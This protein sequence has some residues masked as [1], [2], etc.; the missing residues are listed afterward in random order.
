MRGQVLVEENRRYHKLKRICWGLFCGTLALIV[1]VLILLYL[2]SQGPARGER[3]V[4]RLTDH[5]FRFAGQEVP[6]ELYVDPRSLTEASAVPED[7][8]P[9]DILIGLDNSLSMTFEDSDET[10][11]ERVKKV[12]LSFLDST[13][14]ERHQVGIARLDEEARVLQTLSR[15][16]PVLKRVVEELPE[17]QSTKV[18]DGLEAMGRELAS[19]RHQPGALSLAIVLTDGRTNAAALRSAAS[20]LTD[21]QRV[22]VAPIGIGDFV[23]DD[24]LRAVSSFPSE[25]SKGTEVDEL[26]AIYR[27]WIENMER[28]VAIDVRLTETFNS[29]SLSLVEASVSDGGVVAD[30]R[31]EWYLPFLTTRPRSLSYRLKARSIGW[32]SIDEVQGSVAL[33]PVGAQEVILPVHRKPKVI[34]TIPL[35][36]LLIPLLLFLLLLPWLLAWWRRRRAAAGPARLPVEIDQPALPPMPPPLLPLDPEQLMRTTEPTLILGLGGAGR[37]VLTF[38]KKAVL[39]TNYGRL[40]KT[41]RFLVFDTHS[42]ELAESRV[43]VGGVELE[44]DELVLLHEDPENPTELLDRTRRMADNPGVDPHLRD[45]WPVEDFKNLPAEQLQ[46]SRGTNQRRPMGRM[47]LYLDLEDGPESSRLWSSIG[48]AIRELKEH[49]DPTVFLAASASGGT[50]SGMFIDVAYL[51]RKI[52]YAEGAKGVTVNLLLALQNTYASLSDSLGLT[53]PNAFAALKE[54]D[55]LLACRDRRLPMTYSPEATNPANGRLDSP[56]LDNCYLFDAQRESYPLVGEHP[57]RGIYPAMAD[58]IHTFLYTTPGGAFDQELK[59]RKVVGDLEQEESGHG[60][61]SSLGTFVFRLPMYDFLQSLKYRFARELAA[62]YFGVFRDENGHWSQTILLATDQEATAENLEEFLYEPGDDRS[63]AEILQSIAS[64]DPEWLYAIVEADNAYKAREDY[65]G[66]HRSNAQRHLSAFAMGLLNPDLDRGT[67]IEEPGRRYAMT[68]STFR[69]LHHRVALYRRQCQ[70]RS[71][72]GFDRS[73]SAIVDHI[74]VVYEE[75]AE[76]IIESLQAHLEGVMGSPEAENATSL[77]THIEE[78]EGRQIANRELESGVLVREYFY[79]DD[80]EEK[81]YR[82]YLSE[83]TRSDSLQRFVWHCRGTANGIALELKLVAEEEKLLRPYGEA[84]TE[85][86][87]TLTG[88][89]ELLLQPMWDQDIHPYIQEAH[90]DPGALADKLFERANP[91]IEIDRALAVRHTSKLFTTLREDSYG[92][93]VVTQIYPKFSRR[94]H[95]KRTEFRDPHCFSAVIVL[96]SLPL[97]SLRAYSQGEISYLGV[98]A[99]HLPGLHILGVEHIASRMEQRLERVKEA[100]RAFHPRFI[101][102]LAELERVRQF[103]ECL[104]YGMIPNGLTEVHGDLC[105]NLEGEEIQLIPENRRLPGAGA[106]VIALDTFVNG[107]GADGKTVPFDRCAEAVLDAK[108]SQADP[109]TFLAEL[110]RLL[111]KM[112]SNRELREA[113]RDLLSY[114]SLLIWNE[115]REIKSQKTVG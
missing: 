106:W 8:R 79:G 9:L 7:G 16:L 69:S 73:K 102:Y 2:A 22:F 93:E 19:I 75:T 84:G 6:V 39:E 72:S 3:F 104:I 18:A 110:E 51:A 90:P 25:Y 56:L 97:P 48:T 1:L 53:A 96:D 33:R 112:K 101:S 50:G 114:I 103:A 11:L 31:I 24:L 71:A 89:A 37:W 70:N 83:D 45:W 77:L 43:Q 29:P 23:E 60:V 91:L 52:S 76:Q 38:L 30:N 15:N 113:D 55:L 10:A 78:Q 17:G 109:E 12:A 26:A 5:T 63:P 20:R 107:K 108:R 58:A 95:V 46:I 14:L 66:I 74:L 4:T 99:S 44:T 34:V 98:P 40:P 36:W 67:A 105:L 54:L 87:R 86:A 68:L 62:E 111:M 88:L 13:D 21:Q 82:D 85:S 59:Q 92:E 65:I 61:I 41:V 81:I 115:F 27:S 94:Q 42:A 64:G 57:N 28:L 49:G 35:L 100:K 47:A 32:P 80:L